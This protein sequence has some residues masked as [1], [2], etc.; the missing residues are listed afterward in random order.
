MCTLAILVCTGQ[1]ITFGTWFSLS[2][3]LF[4]QS[5]SGH[6]AWSRY[7]YPMSHLTDLVKKHSMNDKNRRNVLSRSRWLMEGHTVSLCMHS[8][9]YPA[10]FLV[11]SLCT[12]AAHQGRMAEK[13]ERQQ[14]ASLHWL[15]T[16]L[17]LGN[18]I[19]P[20][21]LACGHLWIWYSFT[22]LPKAKKE[23]RNYCS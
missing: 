20:T 18:N 4:P 2:T 17:F 15:F 3:M 22:V 21:A 16:F 9:L 11:C 8:L 1:K 14:K 12:H 23:R 19:E 7:F 10:V 5:N 13:P 6:W